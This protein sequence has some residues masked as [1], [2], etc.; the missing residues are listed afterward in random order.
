MNFYCLTAKIRK[1]EV[2]ISW[3]DVDRKGTSGFCCVLS[4]MCVIFMSQLFIFLGFI[5]DFYTKKNTQY[6]T[7]F[8][9]HLSPWHNQ[10]SCTHTKYSRLAL[11]SHILIISSDFGMTS[12]QRS[13]RNPANL[14]TAFRFP[15]PFWVWVKPSSVQTDEEER[16]RNERD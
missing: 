16:E 8:T 5:I 11:T 10:I 9:Q 14:D 6:I 4:F 13:C 2:K 12:M 3:M 7:T 1:V 15:G